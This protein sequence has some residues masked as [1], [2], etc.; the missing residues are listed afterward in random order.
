LINAG[1]DLC[2]R[3]GATW[4]IGIQHPFEPGRLAWV[5]EVR[6]R[7]VATSG[8]YARGAHILDPHTGQP[9]AALVSVTVVGADL[10]L[11]DAYATTALA[12]GEPGLRW[13]ASVSDH[14]TA[15]ITADGRAFRSAGFPTVAADG[16]RP[17]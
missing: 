12:M 16:D 13:L 11:A 8:T 17:H 4:R 6:D 3:G 5:V 2:A 7:A 1:G 15:A 14:E 10:A 9:A